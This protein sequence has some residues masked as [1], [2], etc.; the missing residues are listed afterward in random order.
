MGVKGIVTGGDVPYRH[1]TAVIQ[2]QPFLAIDRVRYVGEPV[3]GVIAEDEES[4]DEA[5]DQ[6]RAEFE[7]LPAVLDVFSALKEGAQL[8]H[9]ELMEYTRTGAVHPVEGTNICNHFKLRKGNIEE[10]FLKSD[11]IVEDTYSVPMIQHA[12]LETHAATAKLD[13]DG[14][15]TIW[16]STQSPFY[17]RGEL[18]RALGIPMNRIRIICLRVGGGFG[19]KHEMRIEHLAV[20]MAMKANYRPVKVVL[21]REEEFVSTLVRMPVNVTIKTGARKDGTLLAQKVSIYWDTG[22]YS[23][24]GPLVTRNA[25]CAAP[26]P[27]VI[28]HVQVD[29]FCVYTNKPLGGAYRGLGVPEVA[30]AH[31]SNLDS[32]AHQLG[33]DPVEIRLRNALEEGSISVMGERA[34]NVGLKECLKRAAEGI[35]WNIRSEGKARG[36]GIA[37]M[38]KMTGTPTSSSAIVRL[39]EDGTVQVLQSAVE[40]GQGE[41]PRYRKLSPKNFVFLMKRSH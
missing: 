26:G 31:E 1:G 40:M 3:V 7:P 41:T 12:P 22:A 28:P 39:N 33:I 8:V 15:M 24:W 27:Y 35:D 13:P 14:S 36:K 20:A 9:E 10:G 37:C 11:V 21:T 23:G 38:C 17:I 29:S 32:I 34:I 2:D 18:A 30:W 25:G 4:A 16:S 6:I 5:V 19:S